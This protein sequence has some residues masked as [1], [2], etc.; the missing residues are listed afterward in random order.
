MPVKKWIFLAASLAVGIGISLIPKPDAL[1]LPED[2]VGNPMIVLGVLAAAIVLWA[3]QVFHETVTALLMSTM[4]VVAAGIDIKVSFAAF[5]GSTTWLLIA[6]FGLGAAIKEC[7][8]LYRVS[9][10]M[11]KVFPMSYRGQVL[12]LMVVTTLTAPFVPSKAA[13]ST[14]LAPL[15]RGISDVAGYEPRSKPAMGLFNAFYGPTCASASLFTTASVTTLALVGMYSPE[16]QAKYGFI[17]WALSA[18]PWFIP[19][20]VMMFG[21]IAWRY[22]PSEKT[23]VSSDYV[24][25]K[26]KELGGWTRN[27]ISM[28]VIMVVTVLAWCTK[29]WTGLEEWAA[30]VLALCASIIFGILPVT[31]WR[32]NV[33]WESLIFISCAI[34]LAAVLPA[35]GIDKWLVNVLGP[36]TESMF[37]NPFLLIVGLGLVMALGRFLILSETASLALFT[38]FFIPLGLA[39][40]INP[41]IIGFILNAFVVVYFLPYQSSVFLS[42]VYSAGE[43]WIVPQKASRFAYI[44]C[45]FALVACFIG[46]FVWNYVMDIWY[47]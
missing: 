16:V 13:K 17:Q 11:L 39:A 3:G 14:V 47:V 4:F 36:R 32:T 37:N 42:A 19:M 2:A 27:E 12:G 21:Y 1:A 44:Y 15:T 24:K 35:V 29:D 34:S 41:W 26:L 45:G 9:L 38:V 20:F 25:D 40:G 31:K 33:A 6:A 10:Q 18:L 7:G 46:Y 8:L 22:R 23:T 5:S 30:A 43:D 28:C